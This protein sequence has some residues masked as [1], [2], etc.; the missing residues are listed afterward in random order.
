MKPKSLERLV[1]KLIN[2]ILCI[3]AVGVG[4][5]SIYNLAQGKYALAAMEALFYTIF[6]ISGITTKYEIEIAE[7]ERKRIDQEIHR[8]ENTIKA[9][10]IMINFYET[11]QKSKGSQAKSRENKEFITERTDEWKLDTSGY[12]GWLRQ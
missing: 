5:H 12:D 8:T 4:A 2:P 3:S 1:L 11:V 10:D 7:Q 9:F 6:A